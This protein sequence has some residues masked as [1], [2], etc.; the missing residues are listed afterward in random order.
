MAEVYENAAMNTAATAFFDNGAGLY[1]TKMAK[2]PRTISVDVD[3][4]SPPVENTPRH[5]LKGTHD[6]SHE[7]AWS[8]RV[9][10]APLNCRE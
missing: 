3:I 10:Q 8:V 5:H 4:I 7:D 1:V 6:L 2:R 9:G